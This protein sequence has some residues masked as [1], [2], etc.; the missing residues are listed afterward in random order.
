MSQIRDRDVA[1]AVELLEHEY[2]ALEQ[3]CA[4]QQS[5]IEL[6]SQ[7]NRELFVKIEL[8]EAQVRELQEA[9]AEAH[10]TGDENGR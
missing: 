1:K 9:L 7:A 3:L 5:D 4:S 6:W 10:L 2:A 8:L